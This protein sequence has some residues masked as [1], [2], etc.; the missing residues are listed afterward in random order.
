[1][2]DQTEPIL[3]VVLHSPEIPPNTGNIGRSCVAIG[4]KLWLVKPLGYLLD[5]KYLRRAGM[6]YWQFLN[7]E[8]VENWEELRQRIGEEKQYWYLTKFATKLVWEAEFTP[9]D[10]LVFGSEGSGLPEE[11]R[12]ENSESC[13]KLP[14]FEQVRSLNLASTAN[15]VMYEA[16]RQFG[17]LSS[18]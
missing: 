15:T 16:I 18:S 9:G 6:D 7:Y 12:D 3:H 5:D 4:A 2:T 17:G 1:M 11:I 14:M 8:V 13:L 10:V